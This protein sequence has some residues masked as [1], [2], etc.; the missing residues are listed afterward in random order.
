MNEYFNVNNP[1]EKNIDY[2]FKNMVYYITAS[3][4]L[5]LYKDYRE[6]FRVILKKVNNKI[7]DVYVNEE[8]L[9]SVDDK[10]LEEVR[11]ELMDLD[12][13]TRGIPSYFAEW[14]LLWFEAVMSLKRSLEAMDNAKNR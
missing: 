9:I 14:S 1:S 12:I 7:L 2:A 8:N 3:T 11:Y 10:D 4:R 5:N 13:E 6:R